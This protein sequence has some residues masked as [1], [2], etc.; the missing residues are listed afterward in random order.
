M[1]ISLGYPIKEM[2]TIQLHIN[3]ESAISSIEVTLSLKQK[4]V[5][6]K[7]NR[8]CTK[9]KQDEVNFNTCSKNYF[10]SVLKDKIKCILPGLKK[11]F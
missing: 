4:T 3:N 5:L 6:N 1:L 10:A 11:N 2:P 8:P 7:S 9:L